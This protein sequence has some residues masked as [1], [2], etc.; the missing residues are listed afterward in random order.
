MFNSQI[1]KREIDSELTDL[2]FGVGIKIYKQ[3]YMYH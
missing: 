2:N 1:N 3:G